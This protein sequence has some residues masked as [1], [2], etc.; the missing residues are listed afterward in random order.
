MTAAG[1]RVETV[2]T[3]LVDL[4]LRRP[5]QFRDSTMDVQAV[6]LVRVRTGD[7]GVGVGEG[8]GPGGP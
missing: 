2:T 5:H 6:L 4:P 7:G 1:P 3:T 8:V